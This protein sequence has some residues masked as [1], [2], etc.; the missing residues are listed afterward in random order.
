M[1]TN[2][3]FPASHGWS[4]RLKV[5]PR[6]ISIGGDVFQSAS[7]ESWDPGDPGLQWVPN[8]TGNNMPTCQP[9]FCNRWDSPGTSTFC[10]LQGSHDLWM[11][12]WELLKLNRTLIQVL[13]LNMSIFHGNNLRIRTRKLIEPAA[14]PNSQPVL[15][16]KGMFINWCGSFPASLLHGK[17]S[18][19]SSW[20][21]MLW[22]FTEARLPICFSPKIILARFKMWQLLTDLLFGSV[23]IPK[24]NTPNNCPPSVAVRHHCWSWIGGSRLPWP[25][26]EAR[27]HR[28]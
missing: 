15:P 6:A 4:F 25:E 24:K 21:V 12:V 17:S 11:H 8:A 3:K 27:N 28:V 26:E 22:W 7:H 19:C 5:G 14:T 13:G 2:H 10:H 23:W 20:P 1:I 9:L 16:P 18:P